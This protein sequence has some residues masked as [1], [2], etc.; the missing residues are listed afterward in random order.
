MTSEKGDK[1]ILSED[2]LW[3]RSENLARNPVWRDGA[4]TDGH[5]PFEELREHLGAVAWAP[6][7]HRLS[8]RLAQSGLCVGAST[9]LVAVV[10]LY[11]VNRARRAVLVECLA[12]WAPRDE[13][14]A[15]VL[16]DVLRPQLEA[17]AGR[18]ARRLGHPDSSE[19]E[20]DVL[21]AACETLTRRPPPGRCER[22][23]AVWS[24]ARRATCLRRT[25]ADPLPERFDM[26]APEEAV[27][28]ERW[29]GLL[30]RAAAAGV[31]SHEEAVLIARTRVDG[32]PLRR[33]A[34]DLGR[35]YDALRMERRRAEAALRSYA[36][37]VEGSSS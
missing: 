37:S 23:E 31:V 6:A 12:S 36:A 28:L 27:P 29:P 16:I 22:L 11:R 13:L 25:V 5:G 9:D 3:N 15:L 4:M 2:A 8:E 34:R 14:A 32:E 18:L 7:A 17:M 1:E 10:E 30:D 19:A 21:G 33:L 20:G 24:A 26:A 35:P